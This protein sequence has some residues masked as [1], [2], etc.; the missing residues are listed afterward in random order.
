MK[1]SI[2]VLVFLLSIGL[3]SITWNDPGAS[4]HSSRHCMQEKKAQ[5]Y[6]DLAIAPAA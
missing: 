6:T 5:A 3:L 4:S 1:K 2:L